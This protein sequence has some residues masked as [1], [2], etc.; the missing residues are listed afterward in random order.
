[1]LVSTLRLLPTLGL[2]ALA[3]YSCNVQ[4]GGDPG[5]SSSGARAPS[6]APESAQ[7]EARMSTSAP[8]RMAPRVQAVAPAA[9]DPRPTGPVATEAAPLPP[10]D[11]RIAIFHSANVEGELDPC[12]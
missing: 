8:A 5:Q 4:P 3:G 1:M 11:Q 10:S 7:P 9:P 2:M 6:L 12:G